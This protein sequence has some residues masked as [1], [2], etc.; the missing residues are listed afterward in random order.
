NKKLCK[1]WEDHAKKVAEQ[2]V[3]EAT[4]KNNKA[5]ENR[6]KKIEVISAIETARRFGIKDEAILN[7]IISRFQLPYTEA[8]DYMEK[9]SA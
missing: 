7:D 2:A 3:M 9:N 1:A 4:E 5:W 8:V 6:T